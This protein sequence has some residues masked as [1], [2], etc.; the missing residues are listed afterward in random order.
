MRPEGKKT[1]DDFGD[2]QVWEVLTPLCLNL[3]H[4]LD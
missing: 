3:R 2:K 4:A 1:I